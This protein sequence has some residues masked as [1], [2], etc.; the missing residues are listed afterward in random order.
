M[1]STRHWGRW[2]AVGVLFFMTACSLSLWGKQ[3]FQVEIY[4]GIS[5]LN[6]KDLNLFSKAEEQYNEVY[7]IQRLL[8]WQG[9]FL[10]DFPEI[11]N[12]LPAGVRVRY[13][14]SDALSISVDLEGF[15]RREEV[16]VSGAFSY[17]PSWTLTQTKKYD[18]YSLGLRGITVMGGLHYRFSVGQST[19]L[20]VGAA[21]GW[22]KAEFDLRSTWSISV[23]LLTEGYN[24]SGLDGGTLEGNGS[25]NGFAAKGM[26]R[27]NRALGRRFGFF[28]ETSATYCRL[29]SISGSGR[30]TRLGIPGET[31]WEGTWGIKKEEIEMPYMSATVSVPT[32][33]WEGWVAGQRE[34]DFVLDLS[35]VRLSAGLY[36]RF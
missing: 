17:S 6:P 21:A 24:F 16:S 28:V 13:R 4:G 11:S 31:N 7:L 23:D 36:L 20:E 10:N 26:L 18:P 27:L 15:K 9:Y 29:K 22:S 8:G 14:L 12:V 5:F 19:E 3:R 33:Y 30:E 32:N 2:A 25:G 1:K 34:R 35:G